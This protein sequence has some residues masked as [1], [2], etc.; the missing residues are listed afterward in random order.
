MISGIFDKNLTYSQFFLWNQSD[1]QGKTHESWNVMNIQAGHQLH[2]M[3]FDGLGADL[4][5]FGDLFCVLA[6][7]DELEDFA[8]SSRQL[9]ERTFPVGDSFQ[10]KFL[11]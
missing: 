3:V 7:G 6:L 2:A 8:L 9:L 11:E 10:G 5:D 4:Q 1:A